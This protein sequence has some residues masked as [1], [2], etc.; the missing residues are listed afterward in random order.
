MGK[1][2][3][4]HFY[5]IPR[6]G[7]HSVYECYKRQ[8]RKHKIGLH[9]N[10]HTPFRVYNMPSFVFVRSPALHTLSSYHYIREH[11]SHK[12]HN[13]IRNKPLVKLLKE[14]RVLD[15]FCGFFTPGYKGSWENRLAAAKINIDKVSFVGFVERFDV[16]MSECLRRIFGINERYC[17]VMK[18]CSAV[19]RSSLRPSAEELKLLRDLRR[20]DYELLSYVLA[21]RGLRLSL[22]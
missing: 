21:K 14:G 20:D 6:T 13:E 5:H 3:I 7:G 19:S 9:N 10:G 12:L 4:V 11:R 18:N 2:K 8:I 22:I 17:G 15:R 16:D 1:P